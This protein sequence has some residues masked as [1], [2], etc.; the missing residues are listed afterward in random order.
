MIKFL[1]RF[2]LFFACVWL[3][4][5]KA[6]L[7]ETKIKTTDLK[8]AISK[9]FKVVPFETKI[10]VMGDS[11]DT[12]QQIEDFQK[13]IEQYI[14]IDDIEV[15][16]S[17]MGMDL[18]IEGFIPLVFGENLP[19]GRKDPW[20]LFIV[21]TSRKG[22]WEHYP[23]QLALAPT[24]HFGGFKNRF[25]ELN[26]L[27]TPDRYQP[28]SFKFRNNDKSKLRIF[29]GGAEVG[30]EHFAIFEGSVGKKVSLTMKG[31][32]Y[33]HVNPILFFDLK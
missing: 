30:G 17:M 33:D 23:Y 22:L 25:S 26:I 10:T 13:I 32:V 19:A 2:V 4:G 24:Q 6:E 20:G 18:V 15:T 31:G 28:L 7:I 3:I 14:E 1:A 27:L 8:K 21:A 9:G 5:C 12:R 11:K 16:K 29:S